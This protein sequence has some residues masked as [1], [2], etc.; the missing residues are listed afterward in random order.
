MVPGSISDCFGVRSCAGTVENAAAKAGIG[1]STAF[2][3]LKDPEM[4][5]RLADLKTETVRR[6]VDALTAGGLES[7]K[8][9]LELQKANVSPAVRHSVAR[10]VLEWGHKLRLGVDIEER[11]RALERQL[12]KEIP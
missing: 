7:V 12:R 9:L 4:K 3:W 5:Q 6:T 1:R 2:R 8:T 10:S 11:L